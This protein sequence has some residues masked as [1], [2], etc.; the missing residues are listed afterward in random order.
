MVRASDPFR[1]VE[2]IKSITLKNVIEIDNENN[3]WLVKFHQNVFIQIEAPGREQ[4]LRVAE[5]RTYL[6][7]RETKIVGAS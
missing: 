3:N 5:W 1:A 4:A 7:R 2:L 6:D